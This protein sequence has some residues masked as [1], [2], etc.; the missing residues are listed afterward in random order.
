MERGLR[1]GAR[2]REGGGGIINAGSGAKI[3]Q[4]GGVT[5]HRWGCKGGGG[6]SSDIR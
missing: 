1:K 3:N 4:E 2:R 5:R 6:R